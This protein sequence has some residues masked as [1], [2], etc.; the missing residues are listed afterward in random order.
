MS[1][2]L[3]RH[4]QVLLAKK[5]KDGDS[6]AWARL[7][8]SFYDAICGYLNGKI[9]GN[10]KQKA[11]DLTQ[12]TFIL[13][14]ENLQKGKYNPYFSFYTFLKNIA[15]F[16]YL[17]YRDDIKRDRRRISKKDI[18]DLDYLLINTWDPVTLTLYLEKLRL[19]FSCCAKPHQILAFLYVKLLGWKTQDVVGDLSIE[20]LGRLTEQFCDEFYAG[21]LGLVEKSQYD[22]CFIPLYKKMEKSVREVYQEPEYKMVLERY[23]SSKVKGLFL[24]VF[25]S[26]NPKISP[27]NSLYDWC[28]KV[29]ERAKKAIEEGIFI[30]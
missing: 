21:F 27:E 10:N 5:A 28:Y 9:G 4:E 29:K 12:D 14:F 19:I 24:K 8:E 2:P 22:S 11:E 26:S 6:N 15:Y 3:P 17:R 25:Y 18:S 7:Y 23:L 13:A 30:R 16:I 20:K 1:K